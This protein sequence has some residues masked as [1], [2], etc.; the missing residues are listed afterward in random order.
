MTVGTGD[1]EQITLRS[2][3]RDGNMLVFNKDNF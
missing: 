3:N 1:N 2:L